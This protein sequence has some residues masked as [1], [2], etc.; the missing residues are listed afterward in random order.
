MSFSGRGGYV[1]EAKNTTAQ[2]KITFIT[3]LTSLVKC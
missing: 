1:S 3:F 2:Q